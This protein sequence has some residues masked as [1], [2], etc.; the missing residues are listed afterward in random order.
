MKEKKQR[1]MERPPDLDLQHLKALSI[2]YYA[3]G[4]LIGAFSSI[5]LLWTLLLIVPLEFVRI[6]KQ[7]SIMGWACGLLLLCLTLSTLLITAGRFL[8][9]SKH[10]L[11]CLIL[12][13]VTCVLVPIGTALGV[14]TLIVLRRPSVRGLFS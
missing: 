14:F 6:P 11:F 10:H 7:P 2:C 3:L 1:T 9:R 13:G 5:F 12:A 8:A 4:G